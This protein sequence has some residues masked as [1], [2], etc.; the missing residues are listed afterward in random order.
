MELRNGRHLHAQANGGNFRGLTPGAGD[1]RSSSRIA[2]EVVHP[3][4]DSPI[5]GSPTPGLMALRQVASR[6]TATNATGTIG[7]AMTEA[8]R[9][10]TSG[11]YGTTT[12]SAASNVI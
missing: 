5:M 6:V 12:V 2:G 10:T 7:G 1:V 3:I 4:P 9:N 8:Q 11:G